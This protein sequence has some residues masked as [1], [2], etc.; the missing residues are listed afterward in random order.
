M[1]RLK[2]FPYTAAIRAKILD[3][4]TL[5]EIIRD[6]QYD[7]KGYHYPD[8]CRISKVYRALTGQQRFQ[9]REPAPD[10]TREEY[11]GLIWDA[12]EKYLDDHC[13]GGNNEETLS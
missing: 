5:E 10:E 4:K 11:S 8:H 2:P 12:L 13:E 6:C 9:F 1:P 7:H 3:G